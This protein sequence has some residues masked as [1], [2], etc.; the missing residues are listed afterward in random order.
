MHTA[1]M[2]SNNMA[3]NHNIYYMCVYNY[4]SI[5]VMLLIWT[6]AL[7]RW[8]VDKFLR[9]HTR[10]FT[11]SPPSSCRDLCDFAANFTIMT[12][13]M[14]THFWNLSGSMSDNTVRPHYSHSITI[15]WVTRLLLSA[16]FFTKYWTPYLSI[17]VESPH[18]PEAHLE[19]A[20]HSFNTWPEFCSNNR[21]RSNLSAIWSRM[22][23]LTFYL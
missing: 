12:D 2:W 15:F 19:V 11:S 16:Q 18:T 9:V 13:K 3:C 4:E 1:C 21:R 6:S 8:L 7:S 5:E 14:K 17:D 20:R 10:Y 22:Q 23:Y